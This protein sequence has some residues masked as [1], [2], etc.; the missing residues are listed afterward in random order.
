MSFWEDQ[1]ADRTNAFVING[2]HYRTGKEYP[3]KGYGFGGEH[4]RIITLA[5][6]VI[7]TCDLWHQG[8]VPPEYRN[9]LPDNA[10]FA[11]LIEVK[12]WN[13]CPNCKQVM[14]RETCPFTSCNN[15]NFVK[16]ERIQVTIK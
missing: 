4:Y 11:R 8:T 16:G 6:Q 5:G 9:Q 15:E 12:Q 13:T 1:L 3:Q 14:N 7:D 2:E 10:K